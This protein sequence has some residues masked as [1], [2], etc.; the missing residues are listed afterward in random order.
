MGKTGGSGAG[1]APPRAEAQKRSIS[2][3]GVFLIVCALIAAAFGGGALWGY[4]R[5]RDARAAWLSERAGLEA[6]LARE[7]SLARPRELLW[8]VDEGLSTILINLAEKNFGLARDEAAALKSLLAKSSAD[9]SDEAR[10]RLTQLGP[11]LEDIERSADAL[12]PDVKSRALRARDLL[13]QLIDQTRTAS[14]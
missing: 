12:S 2:R 10:A 11:V 13:R 9:L 5:M 7:I 4:L 8:Q 14:P 3:F 6:Q 1:A